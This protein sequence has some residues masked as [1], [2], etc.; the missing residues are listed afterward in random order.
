MVVG[1]DWVG[2]PPAGDRVEIRLQTK[3]VGPGSSRKT[4]RM[5][6][7]VKSAAQLGINRT[8]D[9]ARIKVESLLQVPG[10]VTVAQEILAL[11]VQ[12]RIL[13]G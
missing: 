12:V 3:D 9:S 4:A 10:S 2:Q 13:A 7:N 5:S 1:A 8:S 6:L 11:F